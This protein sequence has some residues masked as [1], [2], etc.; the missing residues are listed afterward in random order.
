MMLEIQRIKAIR[1]E[2]QRQGAELRQLQEQ[3][4]SVA[5]PVPAPVGSS[6]SGPF[7]TSGMPNGNMWREM[8]EN[9]KLLFVLGYGVG[10]GLTQAP[11]PDDLMPIRLSNFEVVGVVSAFFVDP[12]NRLIPA[13]VAISILAKRALGKDKDDI[14]AEIE[15]AREWAASP[16][17]LPPAN[18]PK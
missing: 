2:R 10:V 15:A 14:T 17:G 11:N 6:A 8:S 4:S 13:G 18:P 9:E 3:N 5:A 7:L 16:R 12:Q 1:L